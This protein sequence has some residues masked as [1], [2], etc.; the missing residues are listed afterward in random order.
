MTF[1]KPL[2]I[3]DYNW[4]LDEKKLPEYYLE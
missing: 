1:K 2:A 3:N 4:G